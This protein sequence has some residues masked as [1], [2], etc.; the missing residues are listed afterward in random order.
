MD[1][2]GKILNIQRFCTND[3]PGIRTTV[4]FKGCP[5]RCKWCH[6]PESQ[7]MENELM[8]DKSKCVNCMRCVSACPNGCHRSVNMSHE[9]EISLCVACGKCTQFLC[10]ALEIAGKEITASDVIE[11]VMRD[12]L[13]YDNSGGGITLSGGEPLFQKEFCM[14]VL[15]FAKERGLH[16]CM[17]T[18]GFASRKIVKES[19]EYVDVYLFDLKETDSEIHQRFTGVGNEK[20]I[21]NLLLLDSLGK[22]IILRLPVVPSYNDREEHFSSVAK[23]AK[24]L[25]NLVSIELEPYHDFGKV[26]YEKLCRLYEAKNIQIPSEEE[27]QERIL[28]LRQICKADIKKA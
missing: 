10:G 25:K 12:K 7:R 4:F 17:E 26:K 3:G 27:I 5:L 1:V 2:K 20:I 6:N 24:R 19:S 14:T 9:L 28:Q 21:D 16:V 22:K 23:I 15:K 13:Y 11:T 18:C 8:Y